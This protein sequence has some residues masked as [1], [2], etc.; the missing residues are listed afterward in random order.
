LLFNNIFTFDANIKYHGT[1]SGSA[2]IKLF[3]EMS[4]VKNYLF[5]ISKIKEITKER[6]INVAILFFLPFL[7]VRTKTCDYF[8]TKCS[9]SDDFCTVS[10]RAARVIPNQGKLIMVESAKLLDN[11]FYNPEF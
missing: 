1:F 6:K 5:E 11:F 10:V 7:V 8:F 3:L 9:H 4:K 2:V